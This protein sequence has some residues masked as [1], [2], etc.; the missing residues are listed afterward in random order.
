MTASDP[1]IEAS[2]LTVAFPARTGLTRAV[3]GISFT[4]GRERLAI[5][6]ESGSGKSTVCRA[7][8]GLLPARAQVSADFLRFD[9]RNLLD[10]SRRDWRTIRGARVGLVMQ[11]PK[12]ALNPVMSVGAQVA[13][14][15]RFRKN[16]DRSVAWEKA[17]GALAAVGIDN[18]AR[19]A[20]LYP[21]EVS[22]G[23]GQRVMIAAM[24]AL[25][26]DLLIADE[27]TSALDATVAAQVLALIEALVARREMGLILVSHNLG[28]VG[29]FCD[30][31]LVMLRG[32]IIETI[33][34]HDLEQ[35]RHPYTRA[36]LA[37]RPRLDRRA[38][39]PPTLD[40]D[41]VPS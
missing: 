3:D 9:G 28:L 17:V 11:D 24:L 18:P 2:N 36:L 26:P 39:H 16:L 25:D 22:G 15:F 34:A 27:P 40:R 33:H 19:V 37:A 38:A 21:H 35:A 12:Y 6:G 29:R 8:L 10:L 14:V 32:Q 7:L 30:R 31:V 23:M 20:K 1:L 4:A 41:M 13:E 5:V